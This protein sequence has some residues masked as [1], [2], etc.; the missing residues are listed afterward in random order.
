MRHCRSARSTTEAGSDLGL[1]SGIVV[2][3]IPLSTPAAAATFPATFPA[4]FLAAFLAAAAFHIVRAMGT[5]EHCPSRCESGGGLPSP[6]TAAGLVPK[7]AR[8]GLAA[9][10]VCAVGSKYLLLTVRAI[11]LPSSC[12]TD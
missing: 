1:S 12:G 6:H 8:L 2:T 7:G 11:G 4:A 10:L 9:T 5:D 3:L